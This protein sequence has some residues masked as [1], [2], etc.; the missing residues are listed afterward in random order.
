MTFREKLMQDKPLCVSKKYVGGCKG[1]PFDYVYEEKDD[2]RVCSGDFCRA[3]WD[4]EM[5][6]LE[7][8]ETPA[9]RLQNTLT[10]KIGPEDS[11]TEQHDPVNHPSHYASGKV[12]CIDAIESAVHAMQGERAFLTGQVI[13]YMWRWPMKGGI[14][15]LNKAKWYLERLIRFVEETQR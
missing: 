14:E 6:T 3:C 7:K 2:D 4:R 15:D 9:V 8:E 13:K 10:V 1:C 12:E 5:P 11:A